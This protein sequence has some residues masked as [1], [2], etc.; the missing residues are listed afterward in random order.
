MALG[1]GL[2]KGEALGL[3]WEDVDLDAGTL[4]VEQTLQRTKQGL[5]FGPPKTARGRRTVPLPTVC[6]RALT[7]HPAPTERR[8]AG[9]RARMGGLGPRVHHEHRDATGTP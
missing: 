1:V 2:R 9:G 5:S 4:R 7:I 8:A 6:V 3:R